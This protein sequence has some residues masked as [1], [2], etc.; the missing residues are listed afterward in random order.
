MKKNL[1]SILF[2]SL[3]F[4]KI[5]FSQTITTPAVEW[6]EYFLGGSQGGY[7]GRSVAGPNVLFAVLNS[8]Y[9]ISQYKS[10]IKYA[11]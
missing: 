5:S 9:S 3:I 1:L 4:A 2:F 10:I 8:L 7:L 6:S 11:S